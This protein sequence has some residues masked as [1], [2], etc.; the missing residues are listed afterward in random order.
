MLVSVCKR[1]KSVDSS[2]LITEIQR[3]WMLQ[4]SKEV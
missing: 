4:G 1:R 3:D 2:S